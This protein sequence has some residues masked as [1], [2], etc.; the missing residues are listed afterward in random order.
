MKT[1]DLISSLVADR[2]RPAL[3][4]RRSLGMLL[5][6]A[7]LFA[8]G[9]FAYVLDVRAD[10]T[11]AL[12]D[13]HYQ[14]K[15]VLAASVALLGFA[16]VLQLARPETPTRRAPVWAMGALLPL[17]LALIAE[18]ATL[19]FSDWPRQAIG[20]GP[21]NCLTLVPLIS[22]A[23]L[24]ATL[25]ALRNGAPQSPTAAG[26]MAGFAAGGLG[27]LIYAFHC[28]ND[29]PFYVAIWYLAAIGIVTAVG[30]AL[31]RATLRW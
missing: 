29:S 17:A 30:A 2:T 9:V 22:V 6:V 4:P 16:L 28:D 10:F 23:P 13:W 1:D 14:S 15:I 26:A 20:T 7:L 8:V 3:S 31:G 19:P 11:A 25:L 12:R 21:L 27:A 24:V 18:I 5:P